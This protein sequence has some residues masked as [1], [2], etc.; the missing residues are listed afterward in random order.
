MGSGTGGALK[1]GGVVASNLFTRGAK[2]VGRTQAI[3]KLSNI[4]GQTKSVRTANLQKGALGGMKEG[5]DSSR[6]IVSRMGRAISSSVRGGISRAGEV[7]QPTNLPIDYAIGR[8][9]LGLGGV[10]VGAGTIGLGTY[11]GNKMS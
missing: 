1:Q 11:V 5:V 7:I 4:A 2:N 9:I 3:S 10:S 6:G 8:G